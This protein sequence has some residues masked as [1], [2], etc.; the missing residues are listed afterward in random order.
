GSGRSGSGHRS[1]QGRKGQRQKRSRRR[2]CVGGADGVPH[3]IRARPR[4]EPAQGRK[5]RVGA[6]TS[7]VSCKGLRR[8][9]LSFP[10]SAFKKIE[11]ECSRC[12]RKKGTRP[13]WTSPG[14]PHPPCKPEGP[15]SD[16]G[17]IGV[18]QTCPRF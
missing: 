13:H 12:P 5:T 16:L 18:K 17:S 10:L 4:V 7:A 15:D 6:R 2:R 11:P 8:N 1:R 9:F 3:G 14:L